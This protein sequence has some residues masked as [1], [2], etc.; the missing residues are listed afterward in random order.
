MQLQL[1]QLSYRFK[2]GETPKVVGSAASDESRCFVPE[3]ER[4]QKGGIR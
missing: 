3:K 2:C 1:P 4:T